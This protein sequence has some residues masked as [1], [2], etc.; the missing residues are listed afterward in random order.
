LSV[1]LA[2]LAT[3]GITVIGI[4]ALRPVAVA[5]NLVDLPGGRKTHR[6]KVP[7]I[8]GLG[9][10]IGVVF[11]LGIIP[12]LR[13]FLGS[14]LAAFA[15]VACVGLFDDRFGL[16]P[17]IRL[18]AQAA[19][20]IL[21]TMGTGTEISS[22]GD[23]LGLGTVTFHG[24]AEHAITVLCV[25]TAI[26]AINMLDGM[27]GLAGSV[28]TIAV[29][30]LG[31]A[32]AAAG[33]YDVM[34]VCAVLGAA[35]GAFLIFNLPRRGSRR[36]RC[37]MGDAGSTL[38]GIALAWVCIRITQPSVDTPVGEISAVNVL[39]IVGI[40]VFEFFCT[41]F[42]RI[43]RGRS[44]LRADAH[45]FHHVLLRAGFGIRGAFLVFFVWAVLLAV[46]GLLLNGLRVPDY[47]SLAFL[48][49]AGA[50]LMLTIYRGDVLVRLFPSFARARAQ[51]LPPS[52]QREARLARA[53][54]TNFR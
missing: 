17:W 10:F 49:F 34:A 21:V 18:P 33:E 27:D 53:S 28:T 19:A 15:V 29:T 20:A 16:S 50:T 41:F 54:Q 36:V 44:P 51:W 35:A 12:A 23:P 24:F 25:I 32:A 39:W 8:G 30:A 3:F 1:L 11:G 45:H 40:P 5:V 37:F 38:L 43:L 52:E 22:I 46:A 9:M 42:R 47:W 13:P 48:L 6:G 7:I 4:L 2:A 14:L 26:N 31:L